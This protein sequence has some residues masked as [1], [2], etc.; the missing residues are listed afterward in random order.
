MQSGSVAPQR[1]LWVGLGSVELAARLEGPLGGAAI[2]VDAGLQPGEDVAHLGL[3][4]AR[5]QVIDLA[6]G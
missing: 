3:G 1:F 2:D 6:H 4:A 5:G